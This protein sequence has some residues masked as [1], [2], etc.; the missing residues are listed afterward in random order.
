[1]PGFAL[2]I[3]YG[4]VLPLLKLA[5]IQL[6]RFV[7]SKAAGEQDGEECAI[8]T[9]SPTSTNLN[10]LPRGVHPRWMPFAFYGAGTYIPL[11]EPHGA[12]APTDPYWK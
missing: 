11:S 2:Q 7:S 5:D 10:V 3:D 12:S 6:H 4:P 8:R 1:L 9:F